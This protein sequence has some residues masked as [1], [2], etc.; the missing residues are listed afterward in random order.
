MAKSSSNNIFKTLF[1]KSEEKTPMKWLFPVEIVMMIYAL[2]TLCVILFTVTTIK[3][4]EALVWWRVRM[5]LCTVAL[6]IVYRLWTCRF[7]ALARIALL[8][9]T[10]SWWYPDT[11]LLNC[12][13]QNLDHVFAAWD[14]SLFGFQPALV[15]HKLYPSAII[16]ELMAMGYSMYF[17]MFVSLIFYTFFRHYARFQKVSFIVI[18]SFFVY[19]VVFVLIPVAGPQ[20]YYNAVGVDEIA[21][22][23]FPALGSYFADHLDCLPIPGKQH[24]L[25]RNL[26]QMSHDAGERPTAAFPSS[27]VG[28]STITMIC[29]I[30]LKEWKWL[31][32]WAVPYIFL[33]MGTVYLQPH[34]AVDA[35]AGFFTAIG[36]FFLMKWAYERYFR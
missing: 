10:L 35:I 23:N 30:W 11:Y 7:T 33:V 19:Y 21:H 28:I 24:G 14:Q 13:F 6:W 4:P 8:L 36:V 2:F 31:M 5:V 26:V 1:A 20:Y 18:G 29:F 16:S 9:L 22:G 32:L 3:N 12:Q 25:F 17:L 15:W 34:Y 27:H